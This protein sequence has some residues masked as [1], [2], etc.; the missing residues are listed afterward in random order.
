MRFRVSSLMILLLL[1][2][3]FA[4]SDDDSSL[5]PRDEESSSSVC[6]ACALS[7]S[8]DKDL[9][10]DSH[11]SSSTKKISSDSKSSSSSITKESWQYLD[12]S[13]EYDLMT[14]DRDGQ[15]YKIV[16]IG[17]QIWIAENYNYKIDS[18]FC[19]ADEQDNC[20]KYG[21]LYTWAAAQNACPSGWRLPTKDD[22]AILFDYVGGTSYAGK[23]LKSKDG[24]GGEGYGKDSYGFSAIPAGVRLGYDGRF[25]G[26]GIRGDCNFWTSTE[27]EDEAYRIRFPYNTNAASFSNASK[28][29]AYSVR[30]VKDTD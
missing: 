19:Y 29:N 17:D 9:S 4:C 1:V 15:V 25:S 22:Y 12:V 8:A 23:E 11:S 27:Y 7:S 24:W 5:A 2:M 13:S 20:E 26:S 6:D 3:L 28:G 21:R 18:S 10:S 14:D 16:K 30:C